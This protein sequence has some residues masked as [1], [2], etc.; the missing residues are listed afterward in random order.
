ML[1]AI[2][3]NGRSCLLHKWE[4]KYITGLSVYSECKKCGAR[5][6]VKKAG[7]ETIRF[8]WLFSKTNTIRSS[9]KKN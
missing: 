3:K 1:K 5:K 4:V 6:L 8:S 9:P 7:N 2:V